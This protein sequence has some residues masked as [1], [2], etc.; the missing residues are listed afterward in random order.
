MRNSRKWLLVFIGLAI[1][2][3]LF[4]ALIFQWLVP[5]TAAFAVPG[6]WNLV[7]LRESKTIARG[8][9]G[10]PADSAKA[11]DTWHSGPANKQ[12][13]LHIYYMNDTVISAYSIYYNYRGSLIKKDYLIDSSA[14]R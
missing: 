6:K 1:I 11:R 10:L 12:Y 8:Y 4:Y 3:W 5:R 9:F 2:G 13:S 14:I 7:P